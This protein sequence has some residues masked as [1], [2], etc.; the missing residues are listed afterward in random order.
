MGS[1]I[2]YDQAPVLACSGLSE[3]ALLGP[4]IEHWQQVWRIWVEV[5]K[6]LYPLL[7]VFRLF[8][9]DPVRPLSVRHVAFAVYALPGGEWFMGL[10]FVL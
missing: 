1:V 5:A 7:S 8:V 4:G 3:Y 2:Q 9:G 10:E 6:D